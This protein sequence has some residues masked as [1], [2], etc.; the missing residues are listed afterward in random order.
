MAAELA[1]KTKGV[2]EQN[3]QYNKIVE[4]KVAL[5]GRNSELQSTLQLSVCVFF[6]LFFDPFNILTKEIKRNNDREN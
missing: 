6:C 4:D 1:S 5:E 2:E 3:L